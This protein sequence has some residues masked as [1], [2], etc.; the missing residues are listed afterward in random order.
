MA[1]LRDI[2]DVSASEMVQA[3]MAMI[4][5]GENPAALSGYEP[6][7]RRPLDEEQR[8]VAEKYIAQFDPVKLEACVQQQLEKHAPGKTMMEFLIEQ[9]F[10]QVFEEKADNAK[11]KAL[12]M[13]EHLC[14]VLAACHPDVAGRL[15]CKAVK[16]NKAATGSPFG[17][18][19]RSMK[20]VGA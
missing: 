3:V 6:D 7:G 10:G 2:G 20:I 4:G 17:D 18:Q 12:E 1:R 15:N 8:K 13:L 9:R 16:G 19:T 14:V 11:L 5:D